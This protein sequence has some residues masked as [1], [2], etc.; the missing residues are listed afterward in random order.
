MARR[1]LFDRKFVIAAIILGIGYALT[2]VLIGKTFGKDSAGV[3]GV[4]LTALATGLFSKFETLQFR[5]VSHDESIQISLPPFNAWRL[6]TIILA[7]FGGD[8][9]VGGFTAVALHF[10]FPKRLI[11]PDDGRIVA[12]MVALGIVGYFAVSFLVAKAFVRLRYSTILFAVLLAQILDTT[13]K[14]FFVV[15]TAPPPLPPVQEILPAFLEGTGG[16]WMIYEAAALLGAWLANRQG[17]PLLA[18]LGI[19]KK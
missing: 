9:W 18:D 1:E 19:S 13:A 10:A 14:V 8:L 15:M 17:T 7:F 3:A 2:I 6:I 11:D 12:L 16:G 4:A 5:K